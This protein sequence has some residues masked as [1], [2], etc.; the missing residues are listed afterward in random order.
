MT[1]PTAFLATPPARFLSRLPLP[2]LRPRARLSLRPRARASAAARRPSAA[3]ASAPP[4]IATHNG[5]F[6]C[7]EVM[8][9]H[10]LRRLP[11]YA[12]AAV[13]RSRDPAALAAADVVVDVGG[14]YDAPARRFDHHQRGFAEVFGAPGKK[15]AR[16]K[17]SS[18]GLVYKHFGREVV[19]AV[20][21]DAA[22]R[23]P[24]R[25]ADLEAVYLKVYDTFVEA[26]D[27]IDNGIA[28]FDTDKPP[29]Y[30]N[31][32]GLSA[33]VGRMNAAWNEPCSA[34]VQDKNF[35]SAVEVAGAEFD[36]CVLTVARSWLP[37]RSIVARAMA[38]RADDDASG[39]VLVM[40]EWAPWKDHLFAVE[41]AEA[42]LGASPCPVQ[43]VVYKDMTGGSWRVQAVPVTKGSFTSRMPLPEPWRG[44]RDGDLDV[45]AG[46]EG[47]VFVHAGGF[48][49]GNK[50]FEGAME[51]ARKS[52]AMAAAA[53]E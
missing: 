8:A 37:A 21:A 45:L 11:A 27:A 33:R 26:L 7:D 46:I 44:A 39:S 42:E 31:G 18:A 22:V 17:L 41:E 19:A 50:T 52:L 1:A 29:R 14:V 35:A 40:R 47:C 36:A 9:V 28:Q 2:R 43:Y 6:H 13:V 16:T 10:M 49:G 38:A 32:T 34:D 51:M 48:I 12:A 5:T 20:L 25:E 3:M 24:D 30:E 15:R 4:Q 23:L 53:K